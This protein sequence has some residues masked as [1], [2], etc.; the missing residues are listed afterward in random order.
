MHT[1]VCADRWKLRM[2]GQAVQSPKGSDLMS[3]K[4]CTCFCFVSFLF[5]SDRDFLSPVGVDTVSS[6]HPSHRPLTEMSVLPSNPRKGKKNP[7]YHSNKI[8]VWHL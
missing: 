4:T 1:H 3:K 8:V 7:I 6:V 5:C 2:V